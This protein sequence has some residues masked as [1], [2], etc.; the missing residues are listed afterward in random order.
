MKKAKKPNANKMLWLTRIDSIALLLAVILLTTTSC[1]KNRLSNEMCDCANSESEIEL[2]DTSWL[3]IY[4]VFTPNGDGMNE[5]WQ[6]EDIERY[7]DAIVR[8]IDERL[9]DKKIIFESV[10]Y[11]EPWNGT[12]QNGKKPKDGKYRYE[13]EVAG[14]KLTGYVCVFG[15]SGFE[16]EP[17]ECYRELHAQDYPDPFFH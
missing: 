8:V 1:R 3:I 15:T 4:N 7:P 13:I 16:P 17:D 14:R 12:R 5:K 9:L 2:S 6:I 11:A 10:G